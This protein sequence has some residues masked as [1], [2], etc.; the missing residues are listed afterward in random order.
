MAQANPQEKT[1]RALK[2]QIGRQSGM[3]RVAMEESNYFR[4]K[5]FQTVKAAFDDEDTTISV[6]DKLKD[7]L[8]EWVETKKPYTN[9]NSKSWGKK[10]H[11]KPY[12]AKKNTF[13]AHFSTNGNYI[14]KVSELGEV[15]V[16]YNGCF[17]IDKEHFT[18]SSF[19]PKARRLEDF[20][21]LKK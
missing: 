15:P 2:Y 17:G 3:K 10:T 18:I 12:E 16:Y 19:V 4:G 13:L 21:V 11:I 8:W 9:A 7:E 20:F 14:G 6:L 5:F 1:E